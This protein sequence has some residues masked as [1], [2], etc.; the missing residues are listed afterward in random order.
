M[1]L[2]ATFVAVIVLGGPGAGLAQ[3]WERF[4]SS[5]DGFSAT[6]PGTPKVEATTYATQYRQQLPARVYSAQDSMG[7]Y[8]TTVVDYRG[9]EKLHNATVATCRAAYN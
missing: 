4:V 9:L 8:S 3:D 2:I 5:D 7:R 1:R 6:F